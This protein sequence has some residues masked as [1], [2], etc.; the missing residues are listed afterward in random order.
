MLTGSKAQ[1]V[2]QEARQAVLFTATIPGS[3]EGRYGLASAGEFSWSWTGAVVVSDVRVV[4]KLHAIAADLGLE[5][6]EVCA[7][8][9]FTSKKNAQGVIETEQRQAFDW[10]NF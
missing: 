6:A 8:M 1:A 5:V 10:S 2:Q 4:G 3:T 9:I 7:G